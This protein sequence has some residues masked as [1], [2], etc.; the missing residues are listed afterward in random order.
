MANDRPTKL[1]PLAHN[2]F[3]RACINMHDAPL[4][5]WDSSSSEYLILEFNLGIIYVLFV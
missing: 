5:G 2:W 3:N 1:R 4:Q